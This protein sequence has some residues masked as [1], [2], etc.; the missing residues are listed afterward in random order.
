VAFDF[1]HGKKPFLDFVQ[2]SNQADK[3]SNTRALKQEPK[4][5]YFPHYLPPICEKYSV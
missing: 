4:A 2:L 1:S 5:G 3:R